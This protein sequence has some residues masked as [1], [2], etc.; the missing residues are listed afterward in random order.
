M[1]G[2]IGV[3]KYISKHKQS[4]GKAKKSACLTFPSQCLHIFLRAIESICHL[5]QMVAEKAIIIAVFKTLGHNI[6]DAYQ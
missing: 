2:G 1:G 4:V 5:S 3:G 6:C